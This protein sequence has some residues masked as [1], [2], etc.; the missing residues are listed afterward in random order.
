M[1]P[2]QAVEEVWYA[3]IDIGGGKRAN[4]PIVQHDQQYGL[5]NEVVVDQW[6]ADSGIWRMGGHG[7]WAWL[8]KPTYNGE[9]WSLQQVN[10]DPGYYVTPQN[11]YAMGVN[12]ALLQ[13]TG[14]GGTWEYVPGGTAPNG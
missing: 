8:D 1:I 6:G 5:F 13:P 10:N 4:Y 9:V 7:P 11:L 3:P 12:D 2:R 14:L